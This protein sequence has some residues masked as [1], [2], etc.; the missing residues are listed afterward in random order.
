M[1][2]TSGTHCLVD[3]IYIKMIEEYFFLCL[4]ILFQ[5]Q[6]AKG[7]DFSLSRKVSTI[8]DT[9]ESWIPPLTLGLTVKGV[10]FRESLFV[11][12]RERICKRLLIG[13]SQWINVPSYQELERSGMT[14]TVVDG[15]LLIAG[16]RTFTTSKNV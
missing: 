5:R 7:L 14:L 11:C 2:S 8:H 10:Y 12:D 3:Y 16:G 13:H 6:R 15:K 1:D 4:S 9:L